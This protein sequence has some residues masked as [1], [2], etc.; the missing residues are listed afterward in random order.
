MAPFGERWLRKSVTRLDAAAAGVSRKPAKRGAQAWVSLPFRTSFTRAIVRCGGI[1]ARSGSIPRG[2]SRGASSACRPANELRSR[3]H[4]QPE[5]S[6]RPMAETRQGRQCGASKDGS[7]ERPIYCAQDLTAR[8][9]AHVSDEPE[10]DVKISAGTHRASTR[11]PIWRRS[12]FAIA[13]ARS[14]TASS[15]ST[16]MNSRNA[17]GYLS[18]RAS[19]KDHQA[20]RRR[21]VK[22]RL[23]EQRLDVCYQE[24]AALS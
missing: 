23:L 19:R 15:S 20:A 7:G 16:P 2:S 11:S 3:L 4:S 21:H 9:S 13:A 24:K 1:R 5:H 6:V 22:K 10:R 17:V 18:R 12:E 8:S 14:R